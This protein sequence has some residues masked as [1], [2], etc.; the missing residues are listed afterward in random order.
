MSTTY[1]LIISPVPRAAWQLVHLS[2]DTL[3]SHDA[4]RESVMLRSEDWSAIQDDAQRVREAVAAEE[5]VTA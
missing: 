4:V 3:L 2:L 5:E 1:L